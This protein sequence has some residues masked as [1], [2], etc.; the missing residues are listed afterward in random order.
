MSVLVVTLLG[1]CLDSF[2][3]RLGSHSTLILRNSFFFVKYELGP[4]G[5]FVNAPS[6]FSVI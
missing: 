4:V 1:M 5:N 2:I 6:V 3:A